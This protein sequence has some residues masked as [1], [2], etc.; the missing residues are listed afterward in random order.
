MDTNAIYSSKNIQKIDKNKEKKGNLI[1][2]LKDI[3]VTIQFFFF[4]SMDKVMDIETDCDS[5]CVIY[6]YRV[7]MLYT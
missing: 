7:I 3:I 4:N 1:P 2:P 5:H 6:I